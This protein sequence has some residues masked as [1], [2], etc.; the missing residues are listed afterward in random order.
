MLTSNQLQLEYQSWPVT[1]QALGRALQRQQGTKHKVPTP[2]ETS[3]QAGEADKK[4]EKRGKRIKKTCKCYEGNKKHAKSNGLLG[5]GGMVGCCLWEEVT[6]KMC[7]SQPWEECTHLLCAA[8]SKSTASD[9]PHADLVRYCL[10]R[11]E[12]TGSRR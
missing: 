8:C 7:L 11:G 6:W 10:L 2:T 9:I 1:Y 4:K 3:A 12:E 5:G